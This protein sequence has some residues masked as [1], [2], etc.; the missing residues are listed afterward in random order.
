MK[1]L[2]RS[3]ETL[4]ALTNETRVSRLMMLH[5]FSARRA[6]P[7]Y[8]SQLN[9]FVELVN[10]VFK[11]QGRVF[12]QDEKILAYPSSYFIRLFDLLE[13]KTKK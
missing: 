2:D 3:V 12:K 10:T 11:R 13:D 5:C 6:Y 8:I 7:F 1:T 9:K 4:N